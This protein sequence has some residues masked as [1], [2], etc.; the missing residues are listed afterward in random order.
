MTSDRA[1]GLQDFVIERR[2]AGV[3]GKRRA[4]LDAEALALGMSR[5]TLEHKG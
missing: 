1:E 5:M 3:A 2:F 4:A